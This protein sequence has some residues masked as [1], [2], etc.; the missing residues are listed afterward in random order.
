[1]W[2]AIIGLFTGQLPGIVRE[3]FQARVDLAKTQNEKERILTEER[4]H[5]LEARRDFLISNSQWAMYL[6]AAI[7]APF[8]IYL[9]WI[10]GWDKIACKWVNPA[11][12]V[13]TVCT[14]D[15][16]SPWLEGIL[17]SIVALLTLK[18]V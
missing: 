15:P 12:L 5:T 4:I 8:V 11:E 10:I 9:W 6:I 18:K 3:I 17:A 7:L 2:Q 14:T 1:M 13:K 16:L